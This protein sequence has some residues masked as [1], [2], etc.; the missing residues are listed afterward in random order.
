MERITFKEWPEGFMQAILQLEKFVAIGGLDEQLMELIRTRV[1]QINRCAFCLDMHFKEGV[2]NGE[3]PL[4]LFGLSA[5]REM[6][7]YSDKERAALDFAEKMTLLP[8]EVDTDE[9]LHTE[10]NKHF[11]K[12]EIAFLTLA[13]AQINT[14]NRINKS[15]GSAAGHYQAGMLAGMKQ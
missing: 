5:W 9:T 15:F 6:P 1:S 7:F 2:H 10:L 11:S 12:R 4:R 13:V 3:T 8:A 14:W